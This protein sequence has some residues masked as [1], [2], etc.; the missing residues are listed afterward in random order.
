MKADEPSLESVD[1]YISQYPQSVQQR[2]N[3]LR[4]LI[5]S[6]FPE[7]IENISYR[8]PAYRTKPGKRPFV[9]IGVARKH[10]GIYALHG[11]LSPK[12]QKELEP[13]ITGKGTL[14][15]V[16]DQ[17]LPLALIKKLLLEK[18]TELGL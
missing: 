1:D 3:S 18:R 7:V 11:S 13:H 4:S 16:N 5:K 2:L 10:I 9:Y 6:L 14:Q 12:L 17:P 8:M 15:F